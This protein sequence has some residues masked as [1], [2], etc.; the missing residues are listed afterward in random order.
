MGKRMNEAADVTFSNPPY[1][2]NLDMNIILSLKQ[3]NFLK[4]LVCV[5]PSHWLVDM[6]TQLGEKTG[7]H[8]Y[9]KFRNMIQ[10]YV[11]SIEMFNGNPIFGIKLF[12]PCLISESDFSTKRKNT[13]KV[14]DTGEIVWRQV[15]HINDINIHGKKW[16]VGKEFRDNLRKFIETNESLK[17]FFTAPEAPKDKYYVQVARIRGNVGIENMMQEDFFTFIQR[18]SEKNKGIRN[19]SE[20]TIV[21]SLNT[22]DEQNNF[23]NYL[24]TD[25]ARLCLSMV[26]TNQGIGRPEFDLV[27]KLDFTQSWDDDKLFTFFGY[28]KGHAIREY[29][30]TFLP[31]YH[32]LYPNG[33]TY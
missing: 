8:L 19:N 10:D 26:K 13:I 14:K 28:P 12:I 17:D 11:C 23:L 2:Q 7:D 5:H 29:A 24:Q 9:R 3:S 1:T 33:K 15:N 6:K 25:F 31:D 22:E 30:K 27:P 4:K 32:N 20:R 16:Y 18:D 21:F